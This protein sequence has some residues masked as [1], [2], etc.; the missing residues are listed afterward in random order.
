MERWVVYAI[1]SMIFAGVTSVIAKQGLVNITGE[2]GLF[3]R[4][5]FVFV[6]VIMFAVVAVP[7]AQFNTLS[8]K[9]FTWLGLSGITTA[10]S[11]YY[12]YKA[13]EIGKVSTIAIIDKA[14]FVIA[15]ILAWV[16]LGE[17]VSARVVFGCGLILSGLLVVSQK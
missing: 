6:F 9:N 12:Y 2:L 11:W 13:L 5:C 10:V 3:V 17:E 8:T 16:F 14:S 7:R 4:T 15:V 1:I